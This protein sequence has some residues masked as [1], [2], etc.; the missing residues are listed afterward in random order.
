MTQVPFSEPPNT[1][2]QQPSALCRSLSDEYSKLGVGETEVS[3]HFILRSRGRSGRFRNRF[4]VTGTG[5]GPSSHPAL[6]NHNPAR[7]CELLYGIWTLVTYFRE[8]FG[9]VA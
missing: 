8:P 4:A 9:C 5:S 6:G 7:P 3:E 1:I 2:R